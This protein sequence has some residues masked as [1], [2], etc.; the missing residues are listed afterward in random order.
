MLGV[1]VVP[2]VLYGLLSFVIPESPRY[3]LAVGRD[4]RARKVLAEVEGKDT[5]LDARVAEIRTRC[6]ASTSPPS[7]T[8]SAAAATSCRSSGSASACRCSSSSSAST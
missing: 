3:L 4:G 2:S 8:C 7:R 5:D 1:M 6:A